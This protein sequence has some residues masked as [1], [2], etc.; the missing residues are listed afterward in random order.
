[1]TLAAGAEESFDLADHNLKRAK[2]LLIMMGAEFCQCGSLLDQ[3]AKLLQTLKAGW[4]ASSDA[5]TLT[6]V[7][8]HVLDKA[9]TA[10]RLL[11]AAASFYWVQASTSGPNAEFYGRN[12]K[13]ETA[14]DGCVLRLEA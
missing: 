6:P 4:S 7:I 2:Q 8:Q 5:K 10:Q 11:D 3:T 9:A 1:V 12:G 13:A 14:R